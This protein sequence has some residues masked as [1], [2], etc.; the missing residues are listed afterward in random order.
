MR[1]MNVGNVN[2][3]NSKQ[4]NFGMIVKFDL[5]ARELLTSKACDTISNDLKDLT[6][7]KN[8]HLRVFGVVDREF[9]DVL[10]IM[11][12]FFG[13]SLLPKTDLEVKS[14]DVAKVE[15]FLRAQNEKF[16]FS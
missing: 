14:G 11:V 9:P 2:Y 5:G 6:I 13:K 12:E 10:G 7:N 16:Y 4:Q 15:A 8:G 1:V 3:S